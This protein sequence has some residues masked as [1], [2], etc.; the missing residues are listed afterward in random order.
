MKRKKKINWIYNIK[1]FETVS[2]EKY[3]LCVNRFGQL[4][5]RQW[6]DEVEYR[7]NHILFHK[8]DDDLNYNMIDV[9][10][11]LQELREYHSDMIEKHITSGLR[12]IKYSEM[13]EMIAK[14]KSEHHSY[15]PIFLCE[16]NFNSRIHE[17][18]DSYFND[19]DGQD[20]D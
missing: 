7:N 6:K 20:A 8:Y 10:N 1:P 15:H 16:E 19:E 13:D 11:K 14:E 18:D 17:I 3:L 2:D 12:N 5:I 4:T 9:C